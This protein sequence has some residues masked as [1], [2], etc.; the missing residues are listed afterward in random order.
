[1]SNEVFFHI[2]DTIFKK[3]DTLFPQEHGY[4]KNV[5]IRPF[6]EFISRFMGNARIARDQCVFCCEEIDACY[7]SGGIEGAEYAVKPSGRYECSDLHWYTL[8]SMAFYDNQPE[9]AEFYAKKY[10]S[11]ERSGHGSECIEIRAE[12]LVVD[13]VV[14]MFDVDVKKKYKEPSRKEKHLESEFSM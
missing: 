14:D 3:G 1:M 8:A 6:E 11:G 2:S 10:W 7:F 9:M 4:T 12:K 13:H 5:N